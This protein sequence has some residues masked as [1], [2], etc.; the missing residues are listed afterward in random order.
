LQVIFR[1]NHGKPVLDLTYLLNTT[2]QENKPLDWEAFEEMQRVQPLKVMASG[3]KSQ[4]A[5]VMDME[6]GSFSNIEELA[7]CMRAS[8]LLPGVAGPVMN[9]K[10]PR[11]EDEEEK[12][13][14]RGRYDM[15]PRN[16]FD[17]GNDYEPLADALLF[18]PLPYRSAISEGAT[19]VVC[20]RSRPDGVDVTGKSSIFEKMVVRRFLLRKN[21]LRSAY[22][23]MKRNLHKKLYAEQV[24]ELNEGAKDVDRPYSDTSRPHLLPIA[25]PPGS[26]EV[27][28]LETG[29]EAIFQGVRRGFA[30]AYDA[31]VEDPNQRGKG[32]EVAALVFPDEILNYDPLVYT[33]RTESAYETYLKSKKKDD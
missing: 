21:S 22:E 12:D 9:M 29:R 11:G 6:R 26:A 25:V 16:N 19:H 23:Y 18:E 13:G 14:G 3:L 27:P 5:F 17:G 24:I 28:K 10:Y 4:R 20:L 1:R 33:S 30:R 15:R 7:C 32:M 31:L 8:C 2:M